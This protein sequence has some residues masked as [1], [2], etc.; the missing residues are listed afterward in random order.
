LRVE[1]V[2]CRVH[3][4]EL[5][6]DPRVHVHLPGHYGLLVIYYNGLLVIYYYGLL[7][8]Y[9]YGLLVIYYYGLLVIYNYGLLVIDYGLLVIYDRLIVIYY[10]ARNVSQTGCVQ[11]HARGHSTRWSTTRSSKVNLHHA[12]NVGASCGANL[13]TK[14]P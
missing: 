6:R 5:L 3:L 13:V 12:I 2:G 9:Y 1:G 7:V 10:G 11:Q 4:V 14:H 8:I